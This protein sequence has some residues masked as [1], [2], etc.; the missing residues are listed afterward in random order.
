MDPNTA[1]AVALN[2]C[3][4]SGDIEK[5][6]LLSTN[7]ITLSS[8]TTILC[9]TN[10][11]H[12]YPTEGIPSSTWEDPLPKVHAESF[13]QRLQKNIV[14][15][16]ISQNPGTTFSVAPNRHHRLTSY[17]LSPVSVGFSISRRGRYLSESTSRSGGISMPIDLATLC[18]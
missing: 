16:P 17:V 9:T 10:P 5:R 6:L 15:F 14:P 3:F 2:C 7:E 8:S 12:S 1:R 13:L 4:Q 11:I 18:S